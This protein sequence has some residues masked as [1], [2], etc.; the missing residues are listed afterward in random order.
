M[1]KYDVG[2]VHENKNGEKFEIIEYVNINSRKIKF[3]HNSKERI[4]S[5]PH[6]YEGHISSNTTRKYDIGDVFKNNIGEEYEVVEILDSVTRN[7][8]FLIDN[9]IQTVHISNI[10]SGGIKRATSELYMVGKIFYNKKG[11]KFEIIEKVNGSKRKIKFFDTNEEI[12]V[13]IDSIKSGTIS[14]IGIKEY[15]IGKIFKTNEG[16]DVI[17]TGETKLKNKIGINIKFLDNFG[18]ECVVSKGNLEM[19]SISNPY[20]IKI[21]GV[22]YFGVGKYKS[23]DNNKNSKSYQTWVDML[24][25]VYKSNENKF[26]SYKN[27]SVCKEWHNFQNFAEWYDDNYPHH[28]KDVKFQLDK[29]ILQDGVDNKIYSPKTVV[30]LPQ[31]VNAFFSSNTVSKSGIIGVHPIRN[32]FTSSISE[33]PMNKTIHL[34]TFNTKEE[35][36]KCYVDNKNK[37]IDKVKLYLKELNYLNNNIID[38]IK[39]LSY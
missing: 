21:C 24:K 36:R 25:R 31:V 38:S 6:L 30:F 11:E 13:K 22:G 9:S 39:Y 3:I 5:I 32:K 10:K 8:K 33:F 18:H 37:Q 4:L 1:G 7:I 34:G 35:A 17:V 2:T 29:D 12:I 20:N 28:I 15:P 23:R 19:G 26:K 27:C 16:F 14:R